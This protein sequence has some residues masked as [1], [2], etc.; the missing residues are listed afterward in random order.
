MECQNE[1]CKSERILTVRAKCNDMFSWEVDDQEC[2]GYVPR[3][4]GIGGGDYVKFQL[5]LN[6]GQLQGEFPI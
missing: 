4:L 6:C 3:D 2:H 5:C 1:K